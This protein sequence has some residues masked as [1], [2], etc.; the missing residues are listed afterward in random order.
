MI[1]T[2][3]VDEPQPAIPSS[4]PSGQPR[5][6]Y[7]QLV[8]AVQRFRARKLWRTP[9]AVVRWALLV[10]AIGVGAALLIALAVQ[11]LVAQLPVGG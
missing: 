2:G 7:E 9:S 11:V 4:H 5:D 8:N 10:A 1:D 3:E 6:V